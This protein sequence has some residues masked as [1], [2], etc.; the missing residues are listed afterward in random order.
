MSE[1]MGIILT[2]EKKFET[3]IDI[4]NIIA[5][6]LF[7]IYIYLWII[8]VLVLMMSGKSR[9]N[10]WCGIIKGEDIINKKPINARKLL[11]IV[12]L[13]TLI[14]AFRYIIFPH[15][16]GWDAPFIYLFCAKSVN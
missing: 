10:E 3:I 8:L 7:I 12:A 16:Q 11:F 2:Y 9:P 13:S 4:R 1:L 15:P 14:M 5:N 6:E